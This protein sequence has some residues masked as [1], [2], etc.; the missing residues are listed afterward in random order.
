MNRFDELFRQDI[1]EQSE[2]FKLLYLFLRKHHNYS[3]NQ[4]KLLGIFIN[5]INHILHTQIKIS[6][7]GFGG[8]PFFEN[9]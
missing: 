6:N 9:L 3:D 8:I 5:H 7:L 1:N 2:I 4:L